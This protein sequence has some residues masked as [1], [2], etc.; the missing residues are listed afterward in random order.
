MSKGKNRERPNI[1]MIMSDQHTPN[2]TGCYGNGLVK[3]PNMDSL[4]ENGVMFENA[5]CNNPVCVPSRCSML[6]GLYSHKINVWCNADPLLPHLATWPLVLQSAGYETVISGRMHLVWGD[7]LGGFSK[8]LFGDPPVP[9]PRIGPNKTMQGG[10]AP[11]GLDSRLGAIE[12]MEDNYRGTGPHDE[13]ANERAINYLKKDARKP[14]ALYIGYYQPH[15]PFVAPKKYFDLYKSMDPATGL[16]D[17]LADIYLP[18]LKGLSLDR[19]IE[20]HKLKTAIRAYYAMVS[21]VDHLVGEVKNTLE[22]TGLLDNTIIIYT[23][24]HGEMLGRHRLWHKMCFYEDSVRVPL[25]F[26]CPEKFGRGRKIAANVSLLDLFPTFLDIALF[27][28]QIKLDGQS[29]MPFLTGKTKMRKDGVIAESIGVQR[30]FPG[31]MLKKDNL[32]LILY[33]ARKPVLFDL[34]K[35]PAEN[36]NVAGEKKYAKVLKSMMKEIARDWDVEI[37]NRNIEH[38]FEHIFF[39]ANRETISR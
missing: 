37:V 26:S 4:A 36:V 14:F 34:E 2:V 13:E 15:A 28:R 30:G 25:I 16:E 23:S 19:K 32:K 31:R 29:L 35:D 9:V 18:L 20:E 22:Q 39:H 3:T 38:N 11:Q 21:H 6:T 24:D 7:R 5:Y 12:D 17:P 10:F 27:N 1:V 33:H 8:R